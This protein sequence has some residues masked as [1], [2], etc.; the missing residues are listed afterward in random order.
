VAGL[1]LNAGA[2]RGGFA[3]SEKIYLL[4]IFLKLVSV[5]VFNGDIRFVEFSLW[6][7]NKC[8]KIASCWYYLC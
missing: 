4:C 3:G 6:S 1:E 2:R 5:S 7:M 8:G